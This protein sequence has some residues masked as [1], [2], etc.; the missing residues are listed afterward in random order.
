MKR[1]EALQSVGAW[2]ALPL[3]SNLVVWRKVLT[4]HYTLYKTPA[5]PL[6]PCKD[7]VKGTFS[8]ASYNLFPPRQRHVAS[9]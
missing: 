6:I 2:K 4:Q 9:R 8:Y 1:L 3:H 5:I 7:M